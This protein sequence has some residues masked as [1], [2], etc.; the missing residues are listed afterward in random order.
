M[1]KKQKPKNKAQKKKS[2]I[3]VKALTPCTIWDFTNSSLQAASGY[4]E[5]CQ[6]VCMCLCVYVVVSRLSYSSLCI[7]GLNYRT[8]FSECLYETNQTFTGP[9]LAGVPECIGSRDCKDNIFHYKIQNVDYNFK[10]QKCGR[11]VGVRERG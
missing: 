9:I 7:S 11:R 2:F 3:T 8:T 10:V 6:N 5:G 4:R 1:Q